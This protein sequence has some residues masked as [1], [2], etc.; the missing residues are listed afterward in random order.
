[1]E[2]ASAP[3][4]SPAGACPSFAGTNICFPVLVGILCPDYDLCSRAKDIPA[5]LGEIRLPREL[6]PSRLLPTFEVTSERD[7]QFGEARISTLT[8][9]LH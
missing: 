6:S 1:M 2:R 5:M 3:V 7:G 4:A 8:V 9:K